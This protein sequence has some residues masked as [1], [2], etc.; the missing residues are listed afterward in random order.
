MKTHAKP[1]CL[2]VLS[3]SVLLLPVVQDSSFGQAPVK[4]RFASHS[5]GSSYY[6][7]GAAI[8]EM[9][10]KRLPPGSTVD[11][12]PYA[13]SL[14]NTKLV[15]NKEAELGLGA[16]TPNRWAWEGKEAFPKKL[17]N[18]RSLLGGMDT[19]W[20]AVM[21]RSKLNIN[22]LD[23]VR[24][25]KMPLRIMVLPPGSLAEF[26]SRR[27]LEAYGISAKDL[28]SWG[29]SIANNTF[30]VIASM[31]QDG[32]ADCF[33]HLI[34]P[35]HPTVMEMAVTTGIKFLSLND[36]VI[37]RM[38]ASGWYPNVMPAGTFKGQYNDVKTVG[39]TTGII[40]TKDFSDDL[41][42]LVTK[43]VCENKDELVKVYDACK[44]FDPKTAWTDEK[45]GIPIHPAAVKFYK[46]KKWMP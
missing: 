17:D 4:L 43:T 9:L 10:K 1:L 14:G 5:L 44:V 36:E 18:V 20:L 11:V 45:N 28:T 27:L 22:S 33:I 38:K 3:L 34:T 12:L 16:D 46:E 7:M 21:V 25:K 26:G 35:G 37:N 42:Y 32:R 39:I 40:T 31:M 29:G 41:A 6:L 30:E 13:S 24:E 23:E 19:Y 8:A 15:A 2:A